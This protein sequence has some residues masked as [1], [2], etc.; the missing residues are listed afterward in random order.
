MRI[1]RV[2]LIT[3]IISSFL[4]GNVLSASAKV[5]VAAAFY[6][7]AHFAEQVAGKYADV[8]VIMPPGTEPHEY[9]PTPREIKKVY[10]ARIFLFNGAGIDPWAE[11]LQNDLLKKG[12]AVIE[13]IKHF[14]S[15]ELSAS[16]SVHDNSR[17]LTDPHIWLDP[18]LAIKEVEIIRDTF[19][20]ADPSHE[21]R[22]RDN[23]AA[24]IHELKGLH[25][26]YTDGLKSCRIREIIVSHN[27]FGYLSA[28]YDLNIHAITG[29][30]PEEDPSP[31]KMTVLSK[32]ALQK[33]ITHIF[34]EPLGSP[35]PAKT[36]AMEV[37]AETLP[38]NPLGGLTAKDIRDGRTY[39]SVMEDNLHNLRTAMGC[40]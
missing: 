8:A 18:L 29:I 30:S 28:R 39:V 2:V 7:L 5:K 3:V 15:D 37:G 13:M 17:G 25:G 12:T 16:K 27:A 35:K 6:P 10:E 1:K 31:R 21:R 33:N 40:D 23:S 9:E 20:K 26:R 34:F 19:I 14:S 11:R 38:L 36:I 4:A 32:L 24:Y 22:Y